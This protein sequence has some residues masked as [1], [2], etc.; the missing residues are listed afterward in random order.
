MSILMHVG[1]TQPSSPKTAFKSQRLSSL[2]V[3]LALAAPSPHG[4]LSPTPRLHESP[5]TISIHPLVNLRDVLHPTQTLPTQ[6]TIFLT[7]S[8]LLP[9]TTVALAPL[10]CRR[11]SSP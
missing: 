2:Y 4:G 8:G 10:R 11:R 7:A 1:I 6:T 9:P 5:S 3:V